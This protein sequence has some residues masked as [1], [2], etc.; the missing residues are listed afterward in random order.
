VIRLLTP[1]CVLIANVSQFPRLPE[2]AFGS[3]LPGKSQLVS[4]PFMITLPG[5]KLLGG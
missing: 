2:P 4:F 5:R 1:N 3:L